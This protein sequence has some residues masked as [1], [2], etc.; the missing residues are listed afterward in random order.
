MLF[1]KSRE[2]RGLKKKNFRRNE[3]ANANKFSSLLKSK[4]IKTRYTEQATG[5]LVAGEVWFSIRH[6]IEPLAIRLGVDR[7]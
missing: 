5:L 6:Q 3:L 7:P 1:R 2:N 4:Q